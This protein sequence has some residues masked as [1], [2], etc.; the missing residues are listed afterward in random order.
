MHREK[1]QVLLIDDDEEDYLL[2]KDYLSEAGSGKYVLS[3]ASTFRQGLEEVRKRQHDIYLVD[4]RLGAQN[5]LELI[6]TA[7]S[8]GIH[9]PMI[10]LTGQGEQAIDEEA[11]RIG[12]ADYIVK[13]TFDPALLDRSIRYS[14]RQSEIL[15][16]VRRLHEKSEDLVKE[17]TAELAR[18]VDELEETNRSL[19]KHIQE[20]QQTEQA[21]SE[22]R[23]LLM[24]IAHNFPGG[25]IAVIDSSWKYIFVAGQALTYLNL[26]DKDFL[27]RPLRSQTTP[28]QYALIEEPVKLAFAG[29]PGHFEMEAYG[30]HF[31]YY[32]V[33]LADVRGQIVQVMIVSRDVTERKLAEQE[34]QKTLEKERQLGELKSRFVSMASHEFRTPLA[35]ILSSVALIDRYN[36]PEDTEKREKHIARIKSSVKHMTD[37]LNDFLSLGKLEEGIIANTPVLFDIRDMCEDV[38]EELQINAKEGQQ[39]KYKHFG[40]SSQV[41][42]DKQLLRNVLVNLLSNAIKYSREH[43]TV[44]FETIVKEDELVLNVSDQG[45]GIPEEDKKH[46]FSTFFRAHNATNIQGTGLGLNIV[47]RYLDLMNGSISFT[48]ETNQGTT[49]TAVIPCNISMQ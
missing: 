35:T 11:M 22:S 18:A 2:T 32:T 20:R 13:G 10:L 45:I 28:E 27:D 14:L 1:L 49:F 19:R 26:S 43:S 12:A 7:I 15:G 6:N 25:I 39:V 29:K 40:I 4:Y 3:W 30:R 33:P 42:L 46:I 37:T 9:A 31:I 47:K 16:E 41:L 5:G 17:R 44:S 36:K 48:S 21:L 38:R 24:A 23:N 34:L 8:E